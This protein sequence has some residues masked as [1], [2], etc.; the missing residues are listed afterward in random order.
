MNDKYLQIEIDNMSKVYGDKPAVQ[1]LTL[2]VNPGQVFCFLGRNGAGKTTT[3]HTIVGQKNP[4]EGNVR[5]GGVSV[6][7]PDIHAVWKRLGYLSEQP[8]LHDHLTGREFLLF[9]AE[10]YRVDASRLEWIDKSLIQFELGGDANA[11]IRTYSLGMKKKIALLGALV[12]DPDILV[13]DEPTGALDAAG[14][15][16]A[17]DLMVCARDDGKLVFFTTHIMEIAEK[18]ADRLAIIDKGHLIADGTLEELR[19]QF[20]KKRNETLEDLFLRITGDAAKP[21]SPEL[22][23]S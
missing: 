18:L 14:A 7:S 13:F 4:T 8:T 17:K 12:H 6:A 5:I 2:T 21:A 10:L 3:I 1:N 20:G 11:M 19:E 9:L 16:I 22:T 23:G 15:R